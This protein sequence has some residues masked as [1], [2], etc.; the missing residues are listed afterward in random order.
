LYA[1]L[2]CRRFAT[3]RTSGSGTTPVAAGA[4]GFALVDKTIFNF[5]LS[6]ILGL[7]FDSNSKKVGVSRYIGTN[8][9][10]R[11]SSAR[12]AQHRVRRLMHR[13]SRTHAIEATR[14]LNEFIGDLVVGS[15][16]LEWLDAPAVKPKVSHEFRVTVNRM[17]IWHVI[18]T[19]SKWQEVYDCYSGLFPADVREASKHL[20][21]ELE[22]RGVRSFRNT[23]VGH[24]LDKKT[25]RP[26]SA[27]DL[28]AK[29][30]TVFD[31]DMEPFLLWINDP[32]GNESPKTV[33][34]IV[35]HVRNRLMEEHKLT[36]ADLF[37]WKT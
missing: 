16:T 12:A 35:E 11:A 33:V 21:K 5:F 15:R 9:F 18:S 14:L 30:Q 34:G 22:R 28:T 4:T 32:S 37:P 6:D 29:L 19:L 26:L 20:R 31:G 10:L 36:D 7:P 27:E 23:V 2:N 13:S 1:A 17:C 25:K 8:G 24:I 3:A